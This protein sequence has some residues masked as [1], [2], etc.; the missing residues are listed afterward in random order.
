[1]RYYISMKIHYIKRDIENR[2]KY[3][4]KQFPAIALI[5]ARQ[6]GKTTTLQHIL[7]GSYEFYTFDDYDL[8]KK[9]KDDMGFFF[10]K[11]AKGYVFDEIQYV[12]E[13]FSYIKMLIDKE[14][15]TMGKFIFTGS[16]QFLLIKNFSET[17]AGRLGILNMFTLNIR[18]I[19]REKGNILNKDLFFEICEKGTYPKLIANK[20][21]DN[22]EWYD[23]YIKTYVERDIKNLYN[24]GKMTDFHVFLKLLASRVGQVLNLSS[25]AAGI[26]VSVNT[27]KNWI[28]ILEVSNIIFLLR[29]YTARITS[30][31]TKS[32]KIYFYDTGLICNLNGIDNKNE[33]LRS[34][35]LGQIFE[36]FCIS[37]IIKIARTAGFKYD[38]TFFRTREGL[39]VDLLIN[40]KEKV[41]M[42]EFKASSRAKTDMA[43]NIEK[44][45]NR[46]AKLNVDKGFVVTMNEQ[47][48]KILSRRVKSI[49]LMKLIS[50]LL[51]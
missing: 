43:I 3:Y 46:L 18:E 24:I 17:L 25:F 14:P 12:P 4:L 33:L 50:F 5:G 42:V 9:A 51:E 16:Q 32:P 47:E 38:F 13:L 6:C 48:E 39:E 21:L 30:K 7:N 20:N 49:N 45:M 1:M 26:G 40:D 23:N 8:R 41:Y 15:M 28:S 2:F 35:I 37:E 10:L 11:E 34:P 29:P 27:I 36:N 44:T 19:L 22:I 31:M